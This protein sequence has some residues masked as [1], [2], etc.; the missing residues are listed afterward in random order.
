VKARAASLQYLRK[1]LDR[2]PGFS[3]LFRHYY[4]FST[5]ALDRMFL[6]RNRFRQ[7][8]I[9]VYGKEVLTEAQARGQ[10]CF[11]LGAH[12]GSFEALHTSARTMASG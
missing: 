3:D 6:L 12:L 5:V 2:T 1:A 11:L 7:F 10:S 9:R 8:E 4:C